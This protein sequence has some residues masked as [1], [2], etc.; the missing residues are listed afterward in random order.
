MDWGWG[1]MNWDQ[2]CWSFG[3]GWLVFESPSV[4]PLPEG[5]PWSPIRHGPIYLN[6]SIQSKQAKLE[7]DAPLQDFIKYKGSFTVSKNDCR[8]SVLTNG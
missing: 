4:S 8:T 3:C 6:S 1:T 7:K 2:I 5:G